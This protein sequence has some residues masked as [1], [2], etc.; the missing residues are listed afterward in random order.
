M[1]VWLLVGM[2]FAVEPTEQEMEMAKSWTEKVFAPEKAENLPSGNHLSIVQETFPTRLDKGKFGPLK[3]GEVLYEKGLN[4]HANAVLEIHV[5][6][7]AKTFSAV[8]GID[9]NENTSNGRGSVRCFV[10]S[11]GKTLYESPILRGGEA[12]VPMSVDLE[13]AKS[14]QLIVSDAGDG[15]SCDQSAWGNATVELADGRK[16]FVSDFA[17]SQNSPADYP[18][19]FVYDGKSSR[20]FLKNWAKET[21]TEKISDR[22]T[23]ETLVFTEP[24]GQLQVTCKRVT[25]RDFPTVEWTLYFKNISDKKTPI[26]EKV[27]SLDTPLIFGE[28]EYILHHHVGSPCRPDDYLLQ[29]TRLNTQNSRKEIKTSGGRPSNSDFPYFNVQAGNQG[30]IA[31]IGWGGQWSSRFEVS[32]TG[33]L[34]L[35]AGQEYCRLYLEPGEEIRT[36]LSVVQFWKRSTWLDAQN[37]WRQ[38]MIAHNI[39]R[40]NG[41]LETHH[42][43]GASSYYYGCNAPQPMTEENQK[44]MIDRYREEKIPL[45]YWWMDAAWYL[46]KEWWNTGTWEIDKSRFPNGLRAVTDYARSKGVKSIVWFEPERVAPNEFLSNEHPDWLLRGTL[47]NLGKRE[48]WEWLVNYFN[49]FIQREGIEF[50]RQDF[51]MDPLSYWLENDPENRQGITEIRH[52]EGYFAYYD[53]LLRRNPGLRI[54]SCASGGRRNDLETMRR[55][56]PLLRSDFVSNPTSQQSQT[57]GISLWIPFHGTSMKDLDDYNLRSWMTPYLHFNTDM[58]D[59]T[60]DYDNMRQEVGHWKEVL[61]PLYDK[62]FY[63][64]TP[65]GL[66][67]D[68]WCAWQFHDPPTGRGAIQV[69]RRSQSPYLVTQLKL[70]GL[71][72]N[73]E[74]VFTC[75]DTGKTQTLSGEQLMTTGWEVRLE[76]RSQAGIWQYQKK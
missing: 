9:H 58:R 46:C 71:E 42:L 72:K 59:R 8:L 63:P 64:L 1:M 66:S 30:M 70:Y 49:D 11:D 15:Y 12:G 51:N 45:D 25:Y 10:K 31:V 14:F 29:E 3:I 36:P 2:A 57:M 61:V 13:G 75:L 37:V 4:V 16:L 27:Q 32:Q 7:G 19:S 38:W 54:D 43:N 67:E 6:E 24:S 52:V 21:F 18:F 34:N 65:P 74:Y 23:L 22:K 68:T 53:E 69:F 33:Q 40:P 56:V 17:V 60:L 50:Y 76:N 41:I 47:L 26:L 39:H 44:S 73:A 48:A 20:T 62:D 35:S 55:A 5:A 28:S